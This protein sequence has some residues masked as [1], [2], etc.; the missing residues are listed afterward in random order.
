MSNELELVEDRQERALPAIQVTH[1]A[2]LTVYENMLM[3]AASVGNIDLVERLI[4]LRERDDANTARKAFNAA[5]AAFKTEAIIV[6]KDKFNTQYRSNYTSLGNLVN[7]VA[8]FLS[9]HGL[10]ADWNI[11]QKGSEI[12]VT[13][14]LSHA[15][16]HSESVPFTVPPDSES[17]KKNP[18]Q[19]IK[20]SVTY[21][22]AVT[23]ESVCGMASTDANMD[24]DGTASAEAEP[25]KVHAKEKIVGP[26]F[27]GALRA[28]RE[29][30]YTPLQM[31][32]YYELTPDQE[33]ALSDLEKELAK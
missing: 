32:D 11:L 16:G 31:R 15:M 21:A 4:A 2:E 17:G 1:S 20:S 9:K 22:K 28:I 3:N 7:T 14:I 8:P 12:T 26:R 6:T 29:G 19:A 18:I 33:T 30:K 10:S 13:C 23:F 5:K 25:E 24:D 27:D